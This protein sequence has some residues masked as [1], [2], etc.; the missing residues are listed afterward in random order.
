MGGAMSQTE[1]SQNPTIDQLQKLYRRRMALFGLVILIAGIAIGAAFAV[2]FMPRPKPF[3]GPEDPGW[4]GLMMAGRLEHVLDLAPDQKEKI[5]LIS[6][7]AFKTLREIQEKAKPEID[8]VIKDMNNKI[9]AA[10]TDEQRQKWQRELEEF[11][12]RFREGWRRGGRRPGD[13]G[14]GRRR[15]PGDP[16]RSRRG[17]GGWR[18]DDPNR[19]RRGPGQFGPGFRPDDPNRS[20]RGPGQFGPGFGPDDPN[21]PR[22]G[23]DREAMY[24]RNRRGG[25]SFGRRPRPDDPNSPPEEP[26]VEPVTPGQ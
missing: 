26:M 6:E 2:I 21:R 24:D 22:G 1:T 5:R 18:P 3:P 10:L 4:A 8:V 15:G 20:R 23:F 19:S 13:D 16:N 9:S 14:P 7:T 11:Q 17:S 12:R 25:G